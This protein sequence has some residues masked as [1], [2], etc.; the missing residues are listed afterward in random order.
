MNRN[1]VDVVKEYKNY[2]LNRVLN[3]VFDFST[4]HQHQYGSIPRNIDVI[5]NLKFNVTGKKNA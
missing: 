2:I 1:K 3:G 5:P 4:W